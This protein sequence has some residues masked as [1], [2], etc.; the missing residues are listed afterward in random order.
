MLSIKKKSK[1]QE[2]KER[3]HDQ[4]KIRKQNLDH[5]INQEKKQVLRS[6]FFLINS[7]LCSMV[8]IYDSLRLFFA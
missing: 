3:E 2:K 4:E 6:Y 1:I 5:T 7:H 8:R